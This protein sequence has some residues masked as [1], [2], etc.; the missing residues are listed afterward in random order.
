MRSAPPKP[1]SASRS[2]ELSL[3]ADQIELGQLI[4]PVPI[5]VS[6]DMSNWFVCRTN[7]AERPAVRTF[8]DWLLAESKKT[9][10][11]ATAWLARNRTKPAIARAANANNP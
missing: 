7:L 1:A 10:E 3:L 8:R 5:T 6:A 11:W 9:K 2:L 4:T